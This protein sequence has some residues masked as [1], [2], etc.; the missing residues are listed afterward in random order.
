MKQEI[1]MWAVVNNVRQEVCLT[2][3]G[4]PSIHRVRQ[5]AR[6]WLERNRGRGNTA[7]RV[8]RVKVTI[9]GA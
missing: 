2:D 7:A 6:W 9:E 1:M 8:R 4:E 3:R 5:Q